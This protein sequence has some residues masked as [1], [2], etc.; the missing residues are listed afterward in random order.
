VLPPKLEITEEIVVGAIFK[1]PEI[2]IMQMKGK[3]P[4]EEK[5]QKT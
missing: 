1:Y 4:H 3:S 5:C 2:I